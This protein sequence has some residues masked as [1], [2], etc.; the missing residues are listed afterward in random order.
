MEGQVHRIVVGV[1]GSEGAKKALAWAV[2]EARLRN[3]TIEAVRAWTAGEFG[4]AQDIAS[5]ALKNLEEDVAEVLGSAS[6]VAVTAK[7]DQGSAG[8]VLI[9]HARD[10]DML[11]VGSRGRGGFT[12]LLLGSVSHQVAAHSGAPVVVVV[13]A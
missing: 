6:D 11:V 5:F 2:E 13:K 8:K 3:S 9:D 12:G 10:A 4:T 1:D 7:V